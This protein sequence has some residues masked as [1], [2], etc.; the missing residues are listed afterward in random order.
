[1]GPSLSWYR[2]NYYLFY[3]GGASAIYLE[4]GFD[5]FFVPG[6]GTHP[7]QLNPLGRITDE[8]MRFAERHPD[9]GTPYTPI[10]FLLDPAHGWDMVSMPH[11]SFGV[12]PIDRHDYALRELFG[13][14]YFPGLVVE[15][16]PATS[17]RQTFVNGVFGDV[18]DVLVASDEGAS[19]ADAYKALVVGG[20]IDWTASWVARLADYARKGGTV[21][22]N[23]AQVKGLPPELLG[24][25]LA[26]TQSEAS[27][28]KCLLPG[29]SQA[30]LAGQTFRY[31]RVESRSAKVLMTTE[32]GDPLVTSNEVGKGRVIFCAV[33]DNL[34]LDD[35]LVPAVAHLLEHLCADAT[36]I[37]VTG[38]VEWSVNRT[39]RGWVVTL[40]NNRGVTKLQ[41]GLATV[42]RSETVEATIALGSGSAQSASEW[43]ADE[44]LSIAS[45]RITI[46]I[47]PGDVKIVEIVAGR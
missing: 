19:A 8:F 12:S 34:G 29:E 44:K 30:T 33:P 18:F 17:D 46:R 38:D 21:V 9:R 5:Q 6:P 1:M 7:L 47:P 20:R 3:M 39:E 24:V 22:L 37:R 42:D 32:S 2:K 35:R 43:T 11:W 4:Q 10:A 41:Q 28:A 15:G 16:D 14:A 26:G 13:A 31:E 23:A 27:A 45:G 40:V 25:R 36:P